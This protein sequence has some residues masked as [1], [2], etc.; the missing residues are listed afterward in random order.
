[1]AARDPRPDAL[2]IGAPKAGTSAL[3]AALARHPQVFASR[4]KEPK[5]YL[6]GDAPPPAYCGPGDAHSQ[7]EWVWRRA[8]YLRLFAAAPPSSV[9][10]ESTPFY[11]YS[12]EA[13][14][15]IADDLPDAKVIVV[16]RDPID[17][18]YSN[19]MHLWVDGLEPC[20][21]FVEACGREEERIDAG[22]APFWHYRRMGRY[23]EQL[24]DLFDHVPR[25]RVL[26]LRYRQL[27]SEP[28]A[29][30]NRVS[31]FLGI[32]QDG[33]STVPPDNS[34]PFVEEGWRTTVLGR[35]IRLGAAAGSFAPPQVWRRAS[36]P[37]VA[38]LQHGGTSRRPQLAPSQRQA[39]LEPCLDDIALLERV[40]G[41]SFQDWRSGTGRGSFHERVAAT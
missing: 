11:L 1:V 40:L 22:W 32:D 26:V 41:E 3:H 8:D 29:T 15:R 20:G 6:C 37:L 36:K 24:A 2:L 19:W 39:L 38:A 35:A 33:I 31:R 17:R 13:R 12:A 14:R 28:T 16:V 30:L 34:R 23:G 4:P 18:A 5:Y 9:R 21:D 27:V 10:I 7:R 25:D